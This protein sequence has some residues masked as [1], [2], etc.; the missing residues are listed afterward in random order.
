MW[1]R[2]SRNVLLLGATSLVTDVSSEMVS[3]VLPLY[4]MLELKMTPFEFGV[5]DGIYQ[6]ASALVRVAAGLVADAGRRYKLVAT[7]GYALSA[8]CKL[9]L[10]LVGSAWTGLVGVIVADRIGKGIRTAPR[11]SLIALSSEQ[12]RLGEAFGVHRA[13]D[14]VGAV[15]GPVMAFALLAYAPRA[16]DAIFIVSFAFAAVGV[17]II[18]LF[19]ENLHRGS[20]APPAPAFSRQRLLETLADSRFR[21]LI[22]AGTLLGAVT[23]TDALIYL[24]LQQQGAVPSTF[25]PLLFVGTSTVYLVLALPVGRLADRVGRH[26]LFLAGHVCVAAIYVLLLRDPLP[27]AGIVAAV[28]LLG[29]YYAATD[30]VLAA[31][32]STVLAPG[33]ITAGLA[34]VAT[35][36][37]LAR[38]LAASLFGALWSYGGPH[39]ALFAFGFGMVVAILTSGV[40]LRGHQAGAPHR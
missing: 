33:Q 20:D 13:M 37:A 32:A 3:A 24:L 31:L 9:A 23:A 17:A 40:L 2:L 27:T 12:T 26:W 15:A 29:A 30:G 22:V 25:F 16:Y 21:R 38:L 39:T 14:T 34:I 19:V 1:L 4:F 5:V 11:D 10:L 6:G 7:V 35:A 18:A 28:A 36:V 8:I